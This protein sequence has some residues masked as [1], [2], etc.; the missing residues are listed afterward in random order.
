M[1]LESGS[2][3]KEDEMKLAVGAWL[4]EAKKARKKM[5][6]DCPACPEDDEKGPET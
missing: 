5:A 1:V 2:G 6:K 3:V 4:T